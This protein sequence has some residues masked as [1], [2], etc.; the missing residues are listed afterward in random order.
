MV[1]KIK[2][3]YYA[4]VKDIIKKPYDTFELNTDTL[5]STNSVFKMILS[6]YSNDEKEL[7]EVFKNCIL[8]LNDEYIDKDK[9]ITLKEGDELSVLPP[10]SAG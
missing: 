10:I 6:K 4:S 7:N 2:V 5:E 3:F 1:I 9:A 8:S